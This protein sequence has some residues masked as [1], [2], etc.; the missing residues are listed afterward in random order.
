[1]VRPT[2]QLVELKPVIRALK[3]YAKYIFLGANAAILSLLFAGVSLEVVSS[4]VI[5]NI[6]IYLLVAIGQFG[7]VLFNSREMFAEMRA[8]NKKATAELAAIE[9]EIEAWRKSSEMAQQQFLEDM[10]GIE[11]MLSTQQKKSN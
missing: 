11:A 3:K 2:T 1:M 9:A 8:S 5:I 6:W 4:I 10:K 7:W